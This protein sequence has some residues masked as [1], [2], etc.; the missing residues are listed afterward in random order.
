MDTESCNADFG[1]QSKLD[2]KF[3]Q[4]EEG[5][6]YSYME[7]WVNH[8]LDVLIFK[9]S[10]GWK[11]PEWIFLPDTV[12][13]WLKSIL[14]KLEWF[15]TLDIAQEKNECQKYLWNIWNEIRF[16]MHQTYKTDNRPA[17]TM[18]EDTSQDFYEDDL[19][20]LQ[21]KVVFF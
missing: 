3:T 11:E 9:R 20:I 7:L 18:E 8:I 5:S 4:A 13:D 17:E 1:N 12:G 10:Y 16:S 19:D 14:E 6:F 15:K 2:P 21:L